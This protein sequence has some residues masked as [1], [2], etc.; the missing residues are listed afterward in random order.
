MKEKTF[1][2]LFK[3]SFPC[4]PK[5][6]KVGKLYHLSQAVMEVT[7]G[8]VDFSLV[9]AGWNVCKFQKQKK[10]FHIPLQQSFGSVIFVSDET[11]KMV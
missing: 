3:H 1:L 10:R 5:E 4:L 2:T 9:K 11:K 8:I 7:F 6:E